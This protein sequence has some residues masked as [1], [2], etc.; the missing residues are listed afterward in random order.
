MDRIV[1]FEREGEAFRGCT[2]CDFEEAMP[3][4]GP[5]TEIPTRVNKAD[6]EKADTPVQ[7]VRIIQAVTKH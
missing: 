6:L 7:V 5:A 3:E 2:A 4:A 1:V